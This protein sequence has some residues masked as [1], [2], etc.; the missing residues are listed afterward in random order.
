MAPLSRGPR[1]TA[2]ARIVLLLYV[3]GEEEDEIPAPLTAYRV[4]RLSH[5]LLYRVGV[6]VVCRAEKNLQTRELVGLAKNSMWTGVI[7]E[8]S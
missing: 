2:H 4:A 7:N 8:P 3:Q 1:K 5:R 6:L